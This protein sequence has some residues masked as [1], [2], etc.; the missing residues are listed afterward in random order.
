MTQCQLCVRT[1]TNVASLD[2]RRTSRRKDVKVGGY[3]DKNECDDMNRRCTG[4]VK[5]SL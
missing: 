2:V 1:P 5:A 4:D 3:V